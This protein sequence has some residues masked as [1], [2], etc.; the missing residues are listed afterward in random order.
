LLGHWWYEG[1]AWLA[2]VVEGAQGAGL[3]L[4]TIPEALERHEPQGREL[5]DS[6]WGMDKNLGTWDSPRVA[7]LLWP[8]RR[9]ELA[10]VGALG[11][12]AATDPAAGGA[13]PPAPNGAAEPLRWGA[14]E[15]AARE[16]LA[17]QSSDWAFMS[18]R[19]L[20]ADYPDRRV[21]G[22]TREFERAMASV[23]ED[24]RDSRGMR[25]ANGDPKL[26]GLAPGLRLSALRAPVSAW[27]RQR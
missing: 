4:A 23:R 18:T 3:A 15:R 20:A 10:L 6:S 8:A 14:A 13:L 12:N 26:R 27:G 7:S 17:L 19:E 2:A 1:P 24:M 22:H 11:A 25:E 9:A 16:L 5:T 21:A